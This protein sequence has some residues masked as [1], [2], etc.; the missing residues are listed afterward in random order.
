VSSED[1]DVF[2]HLKEIRQRKRASNR[3]NST[4][5]L[6]DFGVSF[7]QHNHGAHIIIQGRKP[8]V[9]FWPGTGRW[10]VR[11]EERARYGIRALLNYLQVAKNAL[12]KTKPIEATK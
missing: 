9:D 1:Y 6:I 4:N 11:G 10:R 12:D 3:L 7:T 2:R 8:E 5:L